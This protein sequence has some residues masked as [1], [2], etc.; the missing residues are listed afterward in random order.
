MD[1]RPEYRDICA[2]K[3]AAYRKI[4]AALDPVWEQMETEKAR[5]GGK[6]KYT[7]WGSMKRPCP[8]P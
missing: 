3:Y 1:S 8:R 2:K 6:G 7:S 4:V 5:R